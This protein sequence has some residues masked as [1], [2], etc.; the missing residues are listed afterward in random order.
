MVR[1]KMALICILVLTGCETLGGA[2]SDGGAPSNGSN[3]QTASMQRA[4]IDDNP[5]Q[6][7]GLGDAA[8]SAALG[9]PD[10]T[11][12]DGPAEVRQFRGDACVLDLFLYPATPTVTVGPLAV[13]HVELRGPN[14]TPAARRAC[15]VDMIRNRSVTG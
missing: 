2:L 14:L 11:R 1:L 12:R 3:D 10:L 8:I 6:F 4:P 9:D 5:L 13:R 15:M 7:M